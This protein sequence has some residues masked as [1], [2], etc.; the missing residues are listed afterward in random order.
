MSVNK[1]A[2]VPCESVLDIFYFVALRTER[3]PPHLE[4]VEFWYIEC[5]AR[6][7]A[8]ERIH[9]HELVFQLAVKEMKHLCS[10]AH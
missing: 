1:H 5:S 4:E 2:R 10:Q 7:Y 8:K 6:R 9:T 3:N